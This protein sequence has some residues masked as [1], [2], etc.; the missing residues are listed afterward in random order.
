M[1]EAAGYVNYDYSGVL[2][3][4][5]SLFQVQEINIA[6]PIKLREINITLHI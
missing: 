4:L 6:L 1:Y 3:G 2:V 5:L